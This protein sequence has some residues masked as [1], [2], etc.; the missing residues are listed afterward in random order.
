MTKNKRS[1]NLDCLR[2]FAVVIMVIFHFS[3]DLNAFRFAKINFNSGFWYWF[4][5]FIVFCFLF[6]MGMSLVHVH[7]K[8]FRPKIMLKR[9]Y[10][11]GLFALI[12]SITTYFMFPKNWIYFGTL[13]CIAIGTLIGAPLARFPKTNLI[14]SFLILVSIYTFDI[15]FKK[16][17]SFVAVNSMDYIPI[18]PWYMIIGLGI[19]FQHLKLPIPSI[20]N[21]TISQSFSYLGKHSLLIYVLHQPI[22]FGSMFVIYKII[23]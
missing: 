19:F 1:I 6:S 18:Y 5:R 13:H 8:Q 14:I 7:G 22:L 20:G 10:K 11:I 12:I 9:F 21:N 3:Y 23:H 4:P 16:L 2:G 15:T 17:S